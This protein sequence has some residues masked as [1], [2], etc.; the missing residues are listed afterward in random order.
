[1]GRVATNIALG[2]GCSTIGDGCKEDSWSASAE[3]D[4][5]ASAEVHQGNLNLHLPKHHPPSQPS[6]KPGKRLKPAGPQH[7]FPATAPELQEGKMGT[8]TDYEKP[9]GHRD[10]STWAGPR[11]FRPSAM[12][13]P[14][15]GM[16]TQHSHAMADDHSRWQMITARTTQGRHGGER[17]RG[18]PGGG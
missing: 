12:S 11:L 7:S 6:P 17:G 2:A 1:M 4:W 18:G 8:R 5:L 3:V 10:C 13:L 9:F 15:C 14:N 16:W